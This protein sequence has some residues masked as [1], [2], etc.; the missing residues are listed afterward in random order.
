[1][2]LYTRVGTGGG[3]DEPAAYNFED[4]VVVLYCLGFIHGGYEEPNRAEQRCVTD[5]PI[6]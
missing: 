5:Y 3:G 2:R 6:D 4:L 1:L